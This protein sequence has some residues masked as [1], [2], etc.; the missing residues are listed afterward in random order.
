M[1]FN[2]FRMHDRMKV[3][4]ISPPHIGEN[5]RA[6]W[7]GDCFGYERAIKVSTEL[8][9]WYKQLSDMYGCTF[10]NAADIITASHEDS[11]HPTA[12]GHKKLAAAI[13]ETINKEHLL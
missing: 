13:F 5:I 11:I 6:S 3:L 2:H 7:L 1:A 12:E 10:L 9:D 4:L 8:A